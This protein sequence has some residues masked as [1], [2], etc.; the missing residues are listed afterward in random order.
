[1]KK[2]NISLILNR[3]LFLQIKFKKKKSVFQGTDLQ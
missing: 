3:W 2:N 1:M